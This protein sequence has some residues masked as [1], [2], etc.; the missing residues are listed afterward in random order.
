[1]KLAPKYFGPFLILQKVGQV[2]YKLDLPS[3]SRIHPVFHVSC[4]KKKIGDVVQVQTNLPELGEDGGIKFE[5]V[6]VLDRRM[7]KKNNRAVIEVLVQWSNLG[8]GEATWEP[9]HKLKEKYPSFQP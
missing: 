9:L 1:M 7:S 2:A 6:A 5:P 3:E 4:L 8:P